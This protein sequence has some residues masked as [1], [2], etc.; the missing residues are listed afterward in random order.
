[1]KTLHDYEEGDSVVVAQLGHPRN[2]D[3]GRVAK[4]LYRDVVVRF[5]KDNEKGKF[6]A[7]DI[8]EA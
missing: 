5:D 4:A 8:K 7:S 6:A 2:D 1:M 3:T